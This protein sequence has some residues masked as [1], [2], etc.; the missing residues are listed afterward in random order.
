MMAVAGVGRGEVVRVGSPDEKVGVEM[1]V[2]GGVATYV[3]KRD[4][5]VVVER[6][7]LG[8]VME[9]GDFS[10]GLTV[11]G[12][13][14][15]VEK[16]EDTYEMMTGKRR[17][18]VYRA[19]Q[20][21]VPLAA[22]GGGRMDVVWQVSN[23]GAAFRYVF[24]G[25]DGEVKKVRSESTTFRFPSGTV[26]WLQPM[27]T[28]KSG[29]MQS[30]P[31]Y[32]EYYEKGVA[33]GTKSPLG[34]GW[35]YP[36]LFKSGE[37]WVAVTE[38]GGGRTYC[39][40]HLSEGTA[41][42]EFGVALADVREAKDGGAALPEGKLPWATPWRVICVG[43]LKQVVESTLGTD[44]APGPEAKLAEAVKGFAAPG[45]A[46]W[47]WPLLGDKNTTYGV[48]KEFIDYAAEMGWGYC[49]ID[50]LWDKQIGYEKVAEL[51]AYGASKKVGVWVWYNSAG[52]W[53]T[54]P[55]TPRDKLLTHEKR[56]EEFGKLKAMGVKGIKVDFFGGDGLSFMNYYQDILEDA[57]GFGLMVNFH[58]ATLPRGWERTYP[59]LM[60]MEAIRGFEYCTFEQA[61]ADQEPTHAAMLPFTRNL[62][63]PMDFTPVCL[64]RI[65]GKVQRR[66]SSGF[67][68][69]LSVLFTSG[70]QH[71]VETP[72]GMAKM[73]AYV[74]EFLKGV[75]ASWEESKFVEGFPG[76][77]VV[78][79]RKGTGAGGK[80]YVAGI[81]GEE[82]ER[83]MMVD[84]GELGVKQGTVIVDGKEGALFEQGAAVA[85]WGKVGV[86]VK[87]HGGFVMVIE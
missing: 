48:Q 14:G 12:Q 52:D 16:V 47:S 58:G 23:D 46:S 64:D 38:A 42:G 3:V 27:Q 87:G 10:K 36:A 29:W 22:D 61:N 78:M 50:A 82:A 39:G 65:N 4:G 43:T 26:G 66:T 81:N 53:N 40:T 77:Y 13:A 71:Y 35:V 11:A 44:V 6:S 63:D 17:V 51:C 80:W 67:E 9:G 45:K 55:Q 62:F 57:A 59:H 1:A 2:E 7:K 8:V 54:T 86:P 31:A 49:L 15:A 74:K 34:A 30:N 69:A 79:A 72:A 56:V 83:V 25:T 5:V 20:V 84:A 18:N 37:H 19:N 24:H 32:E 33:V 76:K 70:V 73:P 68:L 85:H 28:A 41:D 75:P 60:T 21:V